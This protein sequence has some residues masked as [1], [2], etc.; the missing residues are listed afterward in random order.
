MGPSD[1]KL[2][3]ESQTGFHIATHRYG[4]QSSNSDG[5]YLSGGSSTAGT[6]KG[7]S[8]GAGLGAGSGPSSSA[9]TTDAPPGGRSL[10][11]QFPKVPTLQMSLSGSPHR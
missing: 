5:G 1:L 8:R 10:C 4:G 11:G 3:V 2:A 7:N 9:N 6:S